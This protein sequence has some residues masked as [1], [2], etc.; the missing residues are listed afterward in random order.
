[1]IYLECIFNIYHE[2]MENNWFNLKSDAKVSRQWIARLL[3]LEDVETK[4][5]WDFETETHICWIP[6]WDQSRLTKSCCDQDFIESLAY[7]MGCVK[8]IFET[9]KIYDIYIFYWKIG[10]LNLYPIIRNI[11]A[12]CIL[13]GSLIVLFKVL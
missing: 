1:M 8:L 9:H 7:S 12:F 3:I 4:T 11:L 10:V 5:Q 2:N 6:N 13:Y